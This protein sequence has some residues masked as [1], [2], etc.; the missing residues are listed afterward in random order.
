MNM[1]MGMA[2][3]MVR[4]GVDLGHTVEERDELISRALGSESEGD[5]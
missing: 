4:V 5:G 2:M 3:D 1:A